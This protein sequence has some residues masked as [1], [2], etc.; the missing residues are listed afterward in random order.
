MTKDGEDGNGLEMTILGSLA[1]FSKYTN[2]DVSPLSEL[3]YLFLP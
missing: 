1:I 2:D 3:L